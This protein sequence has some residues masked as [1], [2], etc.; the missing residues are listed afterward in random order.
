[1]NKENIK[2]SYFHLRPAQNDVCNI[3][4]LVD[5]VP[6]RSQFDSIAHHTQ[7]VL[8][9]HRTKIDYDF[10]YEMLW[11]HI[12]HISTMVESVF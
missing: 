6:F 8:T 2:I 5:G 12:K 4:Q 3:T 11:G 10:G 7:S 1:M 9:S